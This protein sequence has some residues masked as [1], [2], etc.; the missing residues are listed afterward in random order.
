MGFQQALRDA[1]PAEVAQALFNNPASF[2]L[3]IV[4]AGALI[5]FADASTVRS[6]VTIGLAYWLPTCCW[7]SLCSGA[8]PRCW[9]T[10][11]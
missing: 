3:A 10:G 4:L 8:R 7:S 1:S 11:T 9:S 2:L 6:R 5:A